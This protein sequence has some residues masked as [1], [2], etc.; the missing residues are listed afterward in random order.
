MEESSKRSFKII[1]GMLIGSLIY[2]YFF[3]YTKPVHR[4]ETYVENNEIVIVLDGEGH[5]Y[6]GD[7]PDKGKWADTDDSY[8]CRLPFVSG[9]VDLYL[10]NRYNYRAP[11][12]E[13]LIFSYIES[14]KILGGDVYLAVDDEEK[15]TY[16][17]KYKGEIDETVI[18]TSADPKIAEISE[19]GVIHSDAPGKTTVTATF[20]DMKDT[21]NVTVT[22]LIVKMPPEFDTS[23]PFLSAELY[24]E[25]DNDLMDAILESRV[26]KAG[27][28]TR[29][30][31]V[32][33]A[34]FLGLEFPYRINYFTEN[35]RINSYRNVEADGEGRYYHKGLYL[36]P[37][38]YVNIDPTR[39][40][41][42]PKPWGYPMAELSYNRVA[43]NGL[44]CSGSITW[45]LVQAGFDPGDIGAGIM[46]GVKDMTDLGEMYW[47]ADAIDNKTIK[48]GD[49][50][51][52]GDG[53][54]AG[55]GHIALLA[56]IDP[57]GYFYVAE[58]LGYRTHWGFWLRK[59]DRNE[60]L[61]YFYWQVDMDE[62][63]GHKDGNLT[64]YWME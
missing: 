21:I 57:D 33:A 11:K 52:G 9:P 4:T 51:S 13:G 48:V 42:G 40:V 15:I 38:R 20:G 24:S 17:T 18:L 28:L 60:L 25:E 53:G 6:L 2:C 62:F 31:A 10:S 8:A 5:C 45:I 61:R 58:E 63:Y 35:G 27:Y 46:A 7:D 12:E 56:A 64:D 16:E 34:R 3:Y 41:S 37:S 30:G 39:I 22:D 47:L 23:K 32:A 36:H 44:D 50:L 54:A 1:L 19:D 55:G 59:Y 43:A 29:A 26:E 14:V 49:L